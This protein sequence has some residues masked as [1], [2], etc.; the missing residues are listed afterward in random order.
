MLFDYKNYIWIV[1]FVRN[2]DGSLFL[3]ILYPSRKYTKNRRSCMKYDK[4]ES[5]ILEAYRSGKMKPLIMFV[6]IMILI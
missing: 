2:K 4:E 1:P 6:I 3:K 5:N